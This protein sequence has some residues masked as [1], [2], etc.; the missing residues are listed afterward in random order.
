MVDGPAGATSDITAVESGR[1]AREDVEDRESDFERVREAI[2]AVSIS[3]RRRCS[4]PRSRCKT[5]IARSL[6]PVSQK[7]IGSNDSTH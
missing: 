2:V 1:A 7:S 6:E 4:L 5:V 3:W